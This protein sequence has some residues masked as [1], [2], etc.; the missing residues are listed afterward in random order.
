MMLTNSA[1]VSRRDSMMRNKISLA[2]L[3]GLM[4]LLAVIASMY[5]SANDNVYVAA[6]LLIVESVAGVFVGFAALFAVAY[7]LGRLDLYIA[8]RAEALPSPFAD[9]RLPSQILQPIDREGD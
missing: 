7:P 3:L 6:C 5:R 9:E 4:T 1:I 8:K 2:G